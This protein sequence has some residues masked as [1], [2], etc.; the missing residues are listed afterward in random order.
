MTLPYDNLGSGKVSFPGPLKS[1]TTPTSTASSPTPYLE[2][3][4]QAI[5]VTEKVSELLALQ[6]FSVFHFYTVG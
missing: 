1:K 2:G 6:A 3:A 4:V 5:F